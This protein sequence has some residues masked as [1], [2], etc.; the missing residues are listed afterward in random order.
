MVLQMFE[1]G[2]ISNISVI[3]MLLDAHFSPSSKHKQKS[4]PRKW[5]LYFGKMELSNSNIKNFL[6]FSQ[7]KAV[8]IFQETETPK[9][10]LLFS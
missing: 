8:H 9:T 1:K 10:F 2:Y 7:K 3:S 6:I 4:T 5:F